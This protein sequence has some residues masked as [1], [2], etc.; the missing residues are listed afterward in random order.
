MTDVSTGETPIGPAAPPEEGLSNRAVA[1]VIGVAPATVDRAVNAS[2]E[3][4]AD[5]NTNHHSDSQDEVASNE[6]L[7]DPVEEM[8]PP[9]TTEYEATRTAVPP[10]PEVETE[11]LES[12]DVRL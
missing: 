1:D 3:A 10:A 9:P 6:A 4:P 12:F 11:V 2:K 5:E 8:P 7:A